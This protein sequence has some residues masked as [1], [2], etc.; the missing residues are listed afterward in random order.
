MRLE[1]KTV[2]ITGAS[3]GIGEA[4]ATLFAKEG[5][6]LLLCA[7]RVDKI[8]SLAGR[9][10]H[11]YGVK[12]YAIK[13]DVRDQKA[14][15]QSYKTLPERWKS[16][17]ILV[18]N[19]GL[20]AGLDFFQEGH[21][22]DWER[23]IDTNVKGLM[24]V[25]KTFVPQMIE[26]KEGHIINIGSIA[27]RQVY[28][29]GIVYCASKHAVRALTQG[30]RQDLHGFNI[31][32][33][34]VDPGAVETEFSQV[35]FKGDEERAAMVYD[36]YKPLQADDIADAV[37]YCATRSPH[38]NISEVLIMPTAQAAASMTHKQKTDK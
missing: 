3:S 29:K 1:K 25:T 2:F 9:L 6:N 7:R 30:L 27:G 20:A 24:Y 26:K 8:N 14:I 37:V 11:D 22:D 13:L 23:M 15:E 19:A 4:C 32:V 31:R 28:P 18:N 16:L 17:D 35:R 33:S 21:V 12:T 10:Q 34:S 38:V 5:A 36:G